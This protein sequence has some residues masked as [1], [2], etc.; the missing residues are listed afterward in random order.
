MI[1]GETRD[2][3]SFNI[4]HKYMWLG[5]I[6]GARWPQ[7]LICYLSPKTPLRTIHRIF[8]DVSCC[9]VVL[10]K[11]IGFLI[12]ECILKK[13]VSECVTKWCEFVVLEKYS[14]PSKPSWTHSTT[15]TNLDAMILWLDLCCNW[16]LTVDACRPNKL[17]LLTYVLACCWVAHLLYHKQGDVKLWMT[18]IR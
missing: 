17:S 6:S 11:S 14:S 10:T 12:I 3:L 9:T 5:F 7:S 1:S 16:W 4:L 8:C 15:H 2:H 13:I 18:W